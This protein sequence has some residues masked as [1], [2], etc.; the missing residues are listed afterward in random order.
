MK[1]IFTRIFGLFFLR[2]G[3][4]DLVFGVHQGTLVGM[5]MQDYKSLCAV[6]TICA[7]LVNT[8]T[9]TQTQ[10]DSI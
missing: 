6:V 5:C 3:H 10:T 2:V 1:C 9:D 4:T 7:T 8:Q